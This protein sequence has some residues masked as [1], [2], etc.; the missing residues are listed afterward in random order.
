MKKKKIK[1]IRDYKIYLW[2]AFLMVAYTVI[3]FIVLLIFRVEISKLV[4][5]IMGTSLFA[6]TFTG[7]FF[8]IQADWAHR[9]LIAMKHRIKE[10]RIR[11]NFII[12]LNLVEYNDIEGAIDIYSKFIPENHQLRDFLY[13]ILINECKY[14]NDPKLKEKYVE[15]IT[16]IRDFYNPDKINFDK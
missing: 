2:I 15:K 12:A 1:L 3:T 7:L 13:P 14:S 9:E 10:Y 16:Y 8:N 11:R 5:I 4:R 6:S